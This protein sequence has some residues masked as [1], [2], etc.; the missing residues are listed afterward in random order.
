MNIV[1]YITSLFEV[2]ETKKVECAKV[3]VVSWLARW[4]NFHG[5]RKRVAKAFLNKDDAEIFAKSLKDA[6]NL[7]QYTESINIKIE[8]HEFYKY[9]A[10]EKVQYEG[11]LK[12][13]RNNDI[14]ELITDGGSVLIDSIPL[15]YKDNQDKVLLPETM[16]IVFPLDNGNIYKVNKLLT[17]LL[18]H[19]YKS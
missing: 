17:S 18:D 14:T 12:M 4:G 6:K 5:E 1:K 8:E 7:L 16:A 19:I 11:S 15:Y 10:G 2:K 3:W 13:K 9:F